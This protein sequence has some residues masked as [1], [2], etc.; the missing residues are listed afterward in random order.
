MSLHGHI[1]E[2]PEM[3]GIWKATIGKTICIQPRQLNP[4]TY[5]VIN[6]EIMDIKKH[7]INEIY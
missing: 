6:T 2:S 3:S 4:L 5:V 7:D 1:H